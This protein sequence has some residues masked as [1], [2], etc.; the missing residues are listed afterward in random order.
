MM[1]MLLTTDVLV[2]IHASACVYSTSANLTVMYNLGA[3][4]GTL[5]VMQVVSGI[6]MGMSYVASEVDAFITLDS[7]QR[8]GTYG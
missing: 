7:A 5:Y 3:C 1:G 2:P 6:T 4:A 8:D